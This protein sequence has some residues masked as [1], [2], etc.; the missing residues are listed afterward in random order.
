M[1][2]LYK[3]AADEPKERG[4]RG[5][6]GLWYDKFCNQWQRHSTTWTMSSNRGNTSPKQAWID[7]VTTQS[8]GDGDE[9]IE[10]AMRLLRLVTRLGG[11][12]QVF[13]ADSSSR[14]VTGLGRSHPVENG[15][16]WHPTLGTPYL[17]GSSVKG[18]V[19]AWAESGSQSDAVRYLMGGQDEVGAIRF[20][21]AVPV[22][23]VQLEADVM[24]PHFSGWEPDDPPGDWRSPT[25]IPFLATAADTD[26]LFGLIPRR[27]PGDI[28]VDLACK[29]L[30]DALVWEGAGA[31]TAVGYGR[32]RYDEAKTREWARRSAYQEQQ[33]REKRE[34]LE[35]R[36]TPEGRWRMDLE[37]LS[38]ANVLDRVR[39]CLG[40]KRLEDPLERLAFARAVDS[41]CSV[42]NWGR[43]RK[44]DPKTQ[45][46]K[47]KLK[48]R[49]RLVR[50]ALAERAN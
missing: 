3:E 47:K 40:A 27:S 22:G 34:R 19:R 28:D 15:F 24:T 5:N 31:K 35:Q 26:F 9:L 1:R 44:S 29:W 13:S 48:E 25:P 32:F 6:A 30:H 4:L 50:D 21:D 33:Q 2:P 12:A 39:V 14:F 18:M 8:I 20:L 23:S 38:E 45:M 41:I 16:V 42:S 46:G 11:R 10:Y 43:G 37:G 36:K 7:T 17:P 49:A